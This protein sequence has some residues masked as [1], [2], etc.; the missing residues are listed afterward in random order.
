LIRKHESVAGMNPDSFQLMVR[1]SI[2]NNQKA[3]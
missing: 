3:F 2:Q 1:Q